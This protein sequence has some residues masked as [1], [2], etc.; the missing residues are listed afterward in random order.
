MARELT[1]IAPS[2]TYATEDNCRKAVEKE[3][4]DA[5]IRW[6]LVW[7]ENGRCYPIFLGQE[8]IELGLFFRGFICV[9]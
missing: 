8:A 7:T 5:D 1:D 4:G 9:G 3:V 6:M 2:K